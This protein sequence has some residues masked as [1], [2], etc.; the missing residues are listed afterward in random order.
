M[1]DVAYHVG[2][3]VVKIRIN[4]TILLDDETGVRLI[5]Y[6]LF[7]VH[8]MEII[9]VFKATPRSRNGVLFQRSIG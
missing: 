9:Y 7:E 3:F 1:S 6:F 5:V 2:A 8:A 4:F